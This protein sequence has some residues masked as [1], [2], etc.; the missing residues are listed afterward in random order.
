MLQDE[1]V[2]AERKINLSSSHRITH[3]KSSL[4]TATYKNPAKPM[5][6]REQEGERKSTN[7]DSERL[8]KEVDDDSAARGWVR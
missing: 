8:G 4:T 7:D 3:H 1:R 2:C 6:E 5:R